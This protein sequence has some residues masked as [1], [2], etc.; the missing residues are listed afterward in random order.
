MPMKKILVVDDNRDAAD[1]LAAILRFEGHEARAAYSGA[2][3][4]QA[5]EEMKPDVVLLD[6]QMPEMSGYDVARALRDYRRGV[7]A[8]IVA[9]TAYGQESDKLA[10]RQAGFHHHITK[11]VDPGRVLEIIAS[12]DQ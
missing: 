11:P 6:I 9:V 5:A 3:A 1:S 12:L 2:E 8:V 7:R 4:V 10:A